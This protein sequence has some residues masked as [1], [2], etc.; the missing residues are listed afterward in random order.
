V[1]VPRLVLVPN[2]SAGSVTIRLGAFPAPASTVDVLDVSGRLI[3]RLADRADGTLETAVVWDGRDDLGRETPNGVYLV[4][5]CTA[6][7]LRTG[8]I[9]RRR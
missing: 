5:A 9:V 4:R 7:G 8:T 2:P 3:R 6:D 1:D